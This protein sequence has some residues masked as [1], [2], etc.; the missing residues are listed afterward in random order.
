MAQATIIEPRR[1]GSHNQRMDLATVPFYEPLHSHPR[2][3]NHFSNFTDRP[4]LVV[5]FQ[6]PITRFRAIG[7]L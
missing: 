7:N 3:A 5:K 6:N 1:L 4:C 2:P